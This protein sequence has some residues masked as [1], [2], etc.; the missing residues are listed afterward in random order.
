MTDEFQR[1]LA[2]WLERDVL[3]NVLE[4]EHADAYP[5]E[6]VEQM[7]EFGLFGATIPTEYGG[8]GLSAARTSRSSR[9]SPRC[10]CRSPALSTRI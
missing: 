10:G 5:T 4:L 7:R 6:M 9:R 3:P 2:R 1:V 8:L